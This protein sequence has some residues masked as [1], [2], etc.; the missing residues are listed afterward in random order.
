LRERSGDP[1]VR[2]KGGVVEVLALEVKSLRGCSDSFVRVQMFDANL[3][4]ELRVPFCTTSRQAEA[5][6]SRTREKEKRDVKDADDENAGNNSA[7][8]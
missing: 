7:M 3:G 4:H 2:R 6:L 5:S 8:R 1:I